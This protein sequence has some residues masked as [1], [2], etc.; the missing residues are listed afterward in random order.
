MDERRHGEL[1]RSLNSIKAL[2][3]FAMDELE[4][5]GVQ[6]GAPG[7]EAQW[8]PLVELRQTL[9]SYREEVIR[10][11]NREHLQALASLDYWFVSTGLRR[12]CGD[13][14]TFGLSGYRW[15]YAIS[16]RI[17]NNDFHGMLRDRF[18]LNLGP[19]ASVHGPEMLVPFMQDVIRHQGHV[20]ADALHSDKVDDFQWLHREFNSILVGILERWEGGV[21]VPGWESEP[22]A[23]LAR[24][25][26]ITL[27]ALVGRAVFLSSSDDLSDAT[28]YLDVAR[29]TYTQPAQLADDLV[30][31]LDQERQPGFSMTHNWEIPDHISG[32]SG[33]VLPERYALI[34]FAVLLMEMAGD[35]TL[36]LNVRGNAQYVLDWFARNAEGL[37]PFLGDTSSVS[38]QQ[39][40]EFA[41]EILKKAARMDLAEE[42][43]RIINREFSAE[44]ISACRGDVHEGM[45]K[46]GSSQRMFEQA[47]ALV[48]FVLG[49]VETRQLMVAKRL[50]K[51]YFVDPAEGDQI[52]CGSPDGDRWGR[53]LADAEVGLLCRELEQAAPMV[54][55]L[56]TMN[57]FFA[58]VD[59]AV[60]DLGLQGNAAIVVAG[61][62][63]DGLLSLYSD[64]AEGYE[65]SWLLPEPDSSAYVGRY[66]GHPVVRGEKD[67]EQ[68]VYVVDL[69]TW[70]TMVRVPLGEGQD[71][72][73]EVEPIWAEQAQELLDG[74]PN[75]IPAEPDEGAKL[76]K[77]QTLVTMKAAVR[78]GFR[79]TDPKRARRVSP[80][81]P[82]AGSDAECPGQC[83]LDG[84][85]EEGM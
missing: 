83:S 18:L 58:A 27:M 5:A 31:A 65:P 1:V 47:G 78:V 38:A 34:C 60:A 21:L 2:V 36:N 40:R 77:L 79:N 8:P 71:V 35:A 70:G 7:S 20:L 74:N 17:E 73:F 84:G 51:A 12:P 24:E 54:A 13:L 85:T 57:E 23:L 29:G 72:R 82:S 67:G 46:F 30:A 68:R 55:P 80:D 75:L 14:F 16:V 26:R 59:A 49:V 63:G 69:D 44:R 4:N 42:D 11:G 50:P 25:N 53:A 48:H 6:C 52:S 3:S 56:D 28:P 32:W 37:E 61:D 19:M 10:G 64:E 39:R 43:F 33:P 45:E 9:L 76:R 15:N 41:I 62:L 81:Q 22:S 66:H